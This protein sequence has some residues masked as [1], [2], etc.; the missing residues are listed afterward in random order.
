MGLKKDCYATIW[1]KKAFPSGKCMN[2]RI[3]VSK[4]NKETDQYE[5][6]F[7]GWCRFVGKANEKVQ[8]LPDRS[9]IKVGDID[10]TNRYD[11]ETKTMYYNVTVWDFEPQ[12][13]SGRASS[14]PA[15]TQA[16]AFT[17]PAEDTLPF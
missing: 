16:S 13:A 11:K 1:E 8:N 6:E 4:K 12:T 3:T 7:S 14:Q 5:D 10:V 17:P 2:V 15:Q 9:R